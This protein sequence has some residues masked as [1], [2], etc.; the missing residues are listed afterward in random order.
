MKMLPNEGSDAKT[1]RVD[2]RRKTQVCEGDVR[3][4]PEGE[5]QRTE[6]VVERNGEGKQ[7]APQTFDPFAQWA[8]FRT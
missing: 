7:A 1:R 2:D 8:K 6:P 4:L 5:A 3:T